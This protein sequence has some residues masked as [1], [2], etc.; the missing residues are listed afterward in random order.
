MPLELTITSHHK[1]LLGDDCV[2]Q[3]REKGG[4]IGRGLQNDWILPDPDR[5]ISGRH[6]TVDYQAGAY[7]LADVSTNGVYLNDEDEPLGRGNPRR[8]FSGDRLRMGDFEFLVAIDEGEDLNMPDR[9]SRNAFAD[10]LE[11]RVQEEPLRTG[12]QLLDEEEITGDEAFQSALFGTTKMDRKPPKAVKSPKPDLGTAANEPA[13]DT[14]AEALL[15][16]FLTAAGI[17]RADIHPSVDPF[18]VMQN[19]GEVLQEFVVGI[20]GMLVSRANLKSMFRLDQTTVLPRH[21]NPLKIAE[22]TDDS[23]KQ[24]LVGRPGEYL[25]PLDSVKEVCRDLKFHQDA[26]MAAMTTAFKDFADRFDPEELQDSFDRTVERKPLFGSFAKPKY[27]QLYCELYPIMTQTSNGPF[28]HQVG[29]E[30]VRAYERHIA[31]Y[32]RSERADGKAA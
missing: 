29:E 17:D 20:T 8:L 31:D 25:G 28:P 14:E 5:F 12:I 6:A 9:S 13:N 10:H 2:R 4:T 19:A 22:N 32:K 18:E 27:W 24:L 11:L 23:M 1:D 15:T 7:Y 16:T 30:F 26:L 3:F 21:N